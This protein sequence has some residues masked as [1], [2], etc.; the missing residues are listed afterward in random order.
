M[1]YY[2]L[3]LISWYLGH[4]NECCGEK[5]RFL[6]FDM[7]YLWLIPLILS[8]CSSSLSLKAVFSIHISSLILE[9][10][11]RILRD[12]QSVIIGLINDIVLLDDDIIKSSLKIKTL[13]LENFWISSRQTT[14]VGDNINTM[15]TTF[16]L[17]FDL[18]K[19]VK[20]LDTYK[21]RSQEKLSILK[22]FL[23]LLVN[24]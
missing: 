13:K 6:K 15:K 5:R 21:H 3:A 20:Q 19:A 10:I 9:N 1:N 8:A 24:L 11:F 16:D 4:V 22:A 23:W 12:V 7:F 2:L 17:N 14:V 18:Y